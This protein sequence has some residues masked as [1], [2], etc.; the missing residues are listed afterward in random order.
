MS[1]GKHTYGVPII[2]WPHKDA[3]LI[4]GNFCSI[5]NNVRIYLGGNH[6]T[7]YVTTYPFGTV[8]NNKKIFTNTNV[9][10]MGHPSTNGNVVIGNDVWICDNVT[11]MSGVTIGDGAIIANNSHVV[12]DV[13]PYTIVGGNPA[14][15]IK[16]RFTEEQIKYLLDIKWWNWDDN[17]INNFT[18]LLCNP[19]IDAFIQSALAS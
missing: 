7:N 11:I 1:Y 5:A 6:I 8:P 13:P 15:V 12:K 10:N 18:H 19:N 4:V 14:K 9:D 3:K 16:Y 17:K 2:V